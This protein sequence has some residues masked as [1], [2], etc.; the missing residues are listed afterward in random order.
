MRARMRTSLLGYSL[1]PV[2][3]FG[4]ILEADAQTAGTFTPAGSMVTPR[5]LHT[6][7]LL[8]DGRV[9]I[10][11]GD[12]SY[13]YAGSDAEATAELYDPVAGT[14]SSTGG[15]TTPRD[16]HTA[17]LLPSGKVLIAGGGPRLRG[18]GYSLASAE[19]YDPATGSFTATGAM[20]VE[21]TLHTATLLNNGKVLIAGGLRRVV[22]S[23]P[24]DLS[25]PRGAELYDPDT[26]TF[27]ATGDMSSSFADT[28]TLLPNGKVLVTRSDPDGIA[29]T[30]VFSD[31]Y[32]PSTGLFSP[33]GNPV[34]GHTVPTATLLPNGK[35][36]VAGGDIG[37]GDGASSKAELYDPD[38]GMFAG[39]GNLTI[40]REQNATVLLPDGTVLFAGGHGGVPVGNGGF[41]NLASVEIY[42]PAT[43]SFSVTGSMLIG[44]DLLQATLLKNGKVLI[45]GGNQY[46]PCCAGGRDPFHPEVATAELYTPAVLVPALIVTDLQFDR[47]N[48]VAGSSYS[49]NVFG[50]NLTSQTFFDVRFIT[51]GSNESGVV[52]NW[53]KRLAAGHDVPA[54]TASGVWAI[55][56][57]RPHQ[58]ETDHTGSFVPVKA[59]ITVA[60]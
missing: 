7:T 56:G 29:G 14:F 13:S 60:P 41:D 3:L 2:F 8:A 48:A 34:S 17:T 32:D 12:S 25:F 5:F 23:A 38:T 57:V 10:A 30:S 31:I 53:Q 15:M 19:I 45:T 6:S 33:A 9:L 22:G 39:T 58:I 52:L 20:S 46:Y 49:V 21:R 55:N 26:G 50:S 43:G 59:T 16:G 24:L 44:R 36:L 28:A 4:F 47:M 18:A 27:T 1:L 54:G 37:D 11:G 51:P 35:V 42:N 40:G